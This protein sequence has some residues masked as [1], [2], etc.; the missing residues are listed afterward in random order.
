[1]DY[2]KSDIN[3]V[4]AALET[5]KEGLSFEDAKIRLEKYGINELE[6][7]Q[8]VTPLK[9]LLN[10]FADFI[11][12]ILFA[13][14]II[15][16]MIG[17]TINFWVISSI[18]AFVV[19][20]GFIQEYK[21][22]KAMEALKKIVEPTTRV[23]R[24]GRRK[25]IQTNEVVPGDI[26]LL[27]TGSSIPAD[28]KIFDIT[29]LKVDESALTGESGSVEKNE[30]DMVFAG[31]QI[32]HGKCKAV[33]T[34]TGMQTKLGQIA[35]MIQEVE[36]KTPLQ[37]KISDLAKSLAILALSASTLVFILGMIKG[38]PLGSMLI[39]ALA[40]AVASVP[41]GLPFTLTLTLAYGMHKMAKQNAL[42]RKMLGVET[43]GSTT[44]ICTDKTGTLTKNEMTVEKVYVDDTFFDITG[45]G[46]EPKGDFSVDG[47]KID[48]AKHENLSMLLKAATLCNNAGFEESV[49][50]LGNVEKQEKWKLIG[51]PTEISLVVAAAKGDMWQD[52]LKNDYR[53][54]EEI[55]FTSERKLMS[56]VHE[57]SG[58][59]C[60]TIF[61]KGAPEFLL[62]KC[63][64]IRKREGVE[65][66][67]KDEVARI[68]ETNHDLA[69]SAYRVL[70]VAHKEMTEPLTPENIEKDMV[71]LGLVAMIDPAREE[72]KEAIVTCRKAG[73][74]VV[75]I[76]GDND[77]TAKAIAKNIGLFDEVGDFE[78]L[79]DE[80]LRRVVADGVITGSELESLD[81][82]E[83]EN[84]VEGV[85]IYAR[86]MPQQKVR[87]VKALQKKGHIVAMTGDGVN[88]APALKKAD[89]GIAMGIK[90]TDVAKE[91]ST[92]VLQDDNFAT[93]VDAVKQ[94]R[95][96]YANIEKFTCYLVSRNF[97][98]VILI[99]MGIVLLGFDFLPL[100]ALQILFINM[101]DEVMPAIGLGLDPA[102]EGIML[103]RPRD[104][105]EKILKK[106][107][108]IMILS[109][110][111]IMGMSAFMVFVLDDPV[112]EI[113]KARTLTFATIVSMILF[114]PFAFR[115]LDD[116]IIK[117]GFF[118]NK[119]LI[120]G[121]FGTFLLTLGVM[122][123]PFFQRIFEL[124]PLSVTD[125]LIPLSVALAA[126]IFAEVI[127]AA[128]KGV[129]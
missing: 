2:N 85:S 12:W 111:F 82:E 104:P 15:S 86:M 52:D 75:M 62:K 20:L 91:S 107:N 96:I 109:M 68:L 48:V 19:I 125:W 114:V 77:A 11:V 43:L 30:G 42:I 54:I 79:T 4:F 76:T 9:V 3:D 61:S 38:A 49:G 41:V 25:E 124:T 59:K 112:N 1:M 90:G 118:T 55:L 34:A 80:K 95:A 115:S 14:A 81:E 93:I 98:E 121:V 74:K 46:Y 105:Y 113:E 66:L 17:E 100:L 67:T 36:E 45:V 110:A 26:S 6:E 28:A 16:L 64:F 50:N 23:L 103:K 40:L 97:T 84:V 126:M 108:L 51:D 27:E 39:I 117:V 70:G 8:K 72:A 35:G 65:E 69:S 58:E 60:K 119:L 123:I 53:M 122:Y 63:S 83:F 7:K 71:F 21:A 101:F 5:S 10:Q 128:T 92:M 89:I 37:I 129:K 56:T 33:V 73:I 120:G 57:K 127:K 24:N 87:I 99:M 94:G 88:D 32:V 47:T 29:G 18:I 22:E 116:S 106:R 102:S 31:T 44:V 13:A 78:D